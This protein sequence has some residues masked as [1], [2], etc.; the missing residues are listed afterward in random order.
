MKHLL[1]FDNFLNESYLE[2]DRQP[3]YHLTDP[4]ISIELID[5]ENLW[6]K[7]IKIKTQDL[8]FK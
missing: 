2:G 3:L 4:H 8:I 1:S 5:K 6:K 7:P